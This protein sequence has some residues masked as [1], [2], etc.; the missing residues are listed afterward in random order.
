M[1]NEGVVY[2]RGKCV[3]SVWNFSELSLKLS[4]HLKLCHINFSIKKF[5]YCPKHNIPKFILKG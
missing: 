4:V 3:R 1:Q 2:I 5:K